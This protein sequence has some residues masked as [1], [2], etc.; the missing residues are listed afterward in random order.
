MAD[1]SKELDLTLFHLPVSPTGKNAESPLKNG[2]DKTQAIKEAF[3]GGLSQRVDLTGRGS[4]V[5]RRPTQP[6]PERPVSAFESQFRSLDAE[7]KKRQDFERMPDGSKTSHFRFH[8]A[9]GDVMSERAPQFILRNIPRIERDTN[10]RRLSWRFVVW[11]ENA[12]ADWEEARHPK[13]EKVEYLGPW[14]YQRMHEL[15]QEMRKGL[16]HIDWSE[17]F[18]RSRPRP[19]PVHPFQAGGPPRV[20][21]QELTLEA[22]PANRLAAKGETTK[23]VLKQLSALFDGSKEPVSEDQIITPAATPPAPK[24][25]PAAP[26]GA[27]AKLQPRSP[28]GPRRPAPGPG[29]AAPGRQPAWGPSPAS[30]P[31][32][33]GPLRRR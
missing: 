31:G 8:M 24:P 23:S 29:G 6:D 21:V 11:Q 2:E 18:D 25:A 7:I 33:K 22:A 28:Y 19:P 4:S 32:T 14:S 30:P 9:L 12:A 15:A 3:W 20:K 17:A 10:L 16:Y 26:A 5:T 27:P 13:M 1:R